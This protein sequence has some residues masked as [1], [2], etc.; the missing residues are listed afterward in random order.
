MSK[1]IAAVRA[2]VRFPLGAKLALLAGLSLVA[3]ITVGIAGAMGAGTMHEQILDV[4]RCQLPATR[5]MG[6]I[7]M[8]HDGLM[9]CAYSAI[10]Q[11]DSTDAAH[12][13]A[14][15]AEA[16][17]FRA[18]F[19]SHLQ[20]LEQ[21]PLYPATK[22]AVAA[23][24]PKIEN[25]ARL[26]DELV[27]TAIQQG[28]QPAKALMQGFQAAFDE[29]ETA[30][31]ALGEAIEHDANSASEA[32]IGLAST[33][34]MSILA[35]SLG[36]TAFALVGSWWI[37]RRLVRRVQALVGLAGQIAAGDF[38]ATTTVSGGDEVG[39]LSLAMSGMAQSL[40]ATIGHV[41]QSSDSGLSTATK[42]AAAS[43]SMAARAS[44]QASGLQEIT[45]SMREIGAAIGKNKQFLAE[46]NELA[47]KSSQSTAD[48]R[49][50]M[51]GLATAMTD[52]T[53]AST[54][55]G[56]VIKV[57]DDIAF[58]T[59]LLA[60][61][62]AVEAA[63]A[64]EAGKG[65]AVVAEEVRNLAQRAAEAARGT[66]QMIEESK[67]RAD[68][69]AAVAQRATASFVAIDEDSSRVSH[70]LQQIAA[71][72]N[73]IGSQTDS[74]ENGLQTISQG[75]QDSAREADDLAN[76]AVGSEEAVQ[77]LAGSVANYRT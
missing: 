14:V 13:E 23:A 73:E 56:K 52:I 3:A 64:G 75:T 62:A 48:G 16:A 47:R 7:D 51:N 24:R 8:Y 42:V 50:E 27:K 57:I 31:E 71:G 39:D 68:H 1:P 28:S 58:Q 32:A 15:V 18:N 59:N 26:G 38:T 2:G 77:Q 21:L 67:R 44:Q 54:E 35:L 33:T 37:G 49:Q 69:G 29:L 43:R 19:A 40:R 20:A 41:K 36:G 63:R 30:N 60:L 66:S 61:N 65:F 10:V 6:L 22:A 53:N 17:S 74:M 4:A 5:H 11:A 46:V 72:S 70:I 76:L 25:Y 45:A 12:K 34:Q 55:V 9:G